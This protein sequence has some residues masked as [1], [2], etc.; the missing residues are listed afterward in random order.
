MRWIGM[1]VGAISGP[2]CRLVFQ[3]VRLI[4]SEEDLDIQSSTR[5]VWS[6]VDFTYLQRMTQ[7]NLATLAS[8]AGGHPAQHYR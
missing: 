5:D 6:L 2:L 7:L 8:M 1:V 4:E 3:A